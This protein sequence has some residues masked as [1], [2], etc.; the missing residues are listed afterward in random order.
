[1]PNKS[2]F[3]NTIK[4]LEKEVG[5]SSIKQEELAARL[6]DAWEQD[7]TPNKTG[8]LGAY[9][10]IFLDI[11]KTWSEHEFSVA[12][13]TRAE[14]LPDLKNCL[15]KMDKALKV[16]AMSLI[17]G[18]RENANVLA[19]MSFAGGDLNKIKSNFTSIGK[20]YRKL[21][22]AT[23][24]MKKRKVVVYDQYK[25]LWAEM[26]IRSI[27]GRVNDKDA[28]K[29]MSQDEK[30]DY[31]IALQQYRDDPK[32][33]P[34]LGLKE[35]ELID[36]ALSDWRVVL[37]CPKETSFDELLADQFFKY[38]AK[39]SNA[40]WIEKDVNDAIQEFNKITNSAQKEIEDYKR[41]VRKA[42]ESAVSSP[43]ITDEGAE[44][45]G[46]F[47]EVQEKPVDRE[48]KKRV[49]HSSK[50]M[51]DMAEMVGDFFMQEELPLEISE[52]K[53]NPQHK[54]RE[55]LAERVTDFN[56]KYSLR[57]SKEKL[58]T[59]V[60]QVSALMI[61]AREEKERYLSK[62]N[63]VVIENG[64]EKCYTVEEYFKDI[65]EEK[66]KEYQEELEK[67]NKEQ[68][69]AEAQYQKNLSGINQANLKEPDKSNAIKDIDGI[70]KDA[71]AKIDQR[72]TEA[73]KSME[74]ALDMAGIQGG[75]V[76][77]KNG[78]EEKRYSA[79]QYYET[80][81]TQKEQYAYGEYQK[82]FSRVYKD[83]CKNV[84]EQ[85]YLEGKPTDF[86]A[87]AKDVD[88]L[89]KS[90]MYIANVYDNEKN[91]EVI[92]KSNFGGFSAEQLASFVTNEKDD[93]WSLN[94]SNEEAWVKQTTKAKNILSQWKK[95]KELNPKLKLSEGIRKT[96]DNKRA[97]FTDGKISQK[98][99]LDYTLAVDSYIQSTYST[100][101][102][103]LLSI[104]QYNLDRKALNECRTALGLKEGD[105]LRIAMNQL[106]TNFAGKVSKEEV[107]KSITAKM[108]S[109]FN[110]QTEKNTISREHKVVQD[111]IVAEKKAK[112]EELKT[113]D[114]EPITIDELDERKSI[115][116]GMPRVPQVAPITQKQKELKIAQ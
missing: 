31:A 65:V 96:L 58:R 19:G 80:H 75:I 46:E 102:S 8:F 97:Q 82:M 34:P 20:E 45:V 100:N 54:E 62:N 70:L 52:I 22:R 56:Q 91:I 106:Y 57:V 7:E 87:V 26:S 14:K 86:S 33:M 24:E 32:L 64:V 108:N 111:R 35:K 53:E 101:A 43:G 4:N 84:K 29:A 93:A 15:L 30:I 51:D 67:L 114:R 10:D 103:K 76:I 109:S 116:Q 13:H 88:K 37:N 9:R 90:A 48:E 85:N 61:K 69:D 38:G 17:P 41:T 39:L 66:N 74:E 28:L 110:F 11:L 63:I 27:V 105:S 40:E 92:Q 99:L 95:A 60:E 3:L 18:L 44:I 36:Y 113:K 94:Q 98:E 21:A 42:Q 112:L 16:C 107:F 49:A 104:R 55:F 78:N 50:A 79:S 25:P 73:K 89:F 77:E 83:A 6:Q 72:R 5:I 1:M 81:E 2:I 115:V 47:F 71:K 12:F 68:K 23:A 59:S